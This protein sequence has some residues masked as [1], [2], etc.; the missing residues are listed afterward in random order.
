MKLTLTNDKGEVLMTWSIGSELDFDPEDLDAD[1]EHDFYTGTAGSLETY[2]DERS[3]GHEVWNE[4][5]N[6]RRRGEK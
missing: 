4:I 5:M 3:L 6:N 2:D 1:P